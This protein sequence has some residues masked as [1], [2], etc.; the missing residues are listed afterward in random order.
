MDYA[1]LLPYMKRIIRYEP[2][3]PKRIVSQEVMI[4]LE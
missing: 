3:H 1:I 4:L 2:V